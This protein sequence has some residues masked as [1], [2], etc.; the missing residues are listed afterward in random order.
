MVVIQ[1]VYVRRTGGERENVSA[2]DERVVLLLF[3]RRRIPR[4]EVGPLE[5]AVHVFPGGERASELAGLLARRGV[6]D[7][8]VQE[9]GLVLHQLDQ[10]VSEL[11]TAPGVGVPATTRWCMLAIMDSVWDA[12][13]LPCLYHELINGSWSSWW[14]RQSVTRI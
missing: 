8:Y 1:V 2:S 9:A 13:L 5:V 6:A 3:L 4:L 14:W 12:V 7:R 10:D 11:R